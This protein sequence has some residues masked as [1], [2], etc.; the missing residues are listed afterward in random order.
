MDWELG[1][2]MQMVAK[3]PNLRNQRIEEAQTEDATEGEGILT[4]EGEVASSYMS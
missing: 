2:H 4:I 1:K 3:S